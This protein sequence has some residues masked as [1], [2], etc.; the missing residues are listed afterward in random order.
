MTKEGSYQTFYPQEDPYGMIT[1][2]QNWSNFEFS[3]K[4]LHLQQFGGSVDV[5]CGEERRGS[6]CK[7][8]RGVVVVVVVVAM[9]PSSSVL[10]DRPLLH[11]I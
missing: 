10:A 6:S 5:L 2:Q 1:K 11:R 3:R 8:G 7:K 4:W 9:F